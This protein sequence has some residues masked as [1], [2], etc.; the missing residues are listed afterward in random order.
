MA[1]ITQLN[2]KFGTQAFVVDII[3]P[4]NGRKRI[5]LGKKTRCQSVLYKNSN[6]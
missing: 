4:G 1:S 5:R 3:V 2:L 6:H